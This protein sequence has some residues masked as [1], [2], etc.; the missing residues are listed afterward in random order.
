MKIPVPRGPKLLEISRRSIGGFSKHDMPTYAAALA[1]RML[2]ALFPLLAFLV[3]LLGFLGINGFFEWL[4]EQSY[5]ALQGQYAGLGERLIMQVQYQAQ[6]G[7]L[8]CNSPLVRVGRGQVA[9][10]GPER[11]LWSGG[12]MPRMETGLD[13]VVLCSGP[14]NND[15]PRVSLAADRSAPRGVAGGT[16]RGVHLSVGVAPLAGRARPAHARRVA[17]LLGCPEREPIASGILWVE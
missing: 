5:S 6:G 12:I 1:Y 7:G 3:A 10:E 8:L 9:D 11:R 16:G 13:P 2:F 4:I 14:S 15:N 17:R